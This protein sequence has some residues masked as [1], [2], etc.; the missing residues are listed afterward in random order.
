MQLHADPARRF[1]HRV[2]SFPSTSWH[3]MLS[4]SPWDQLLVRFIYPPWT[5]IFTKYCF[6]RRCI[7]RLLLSFIPDTLDTLPTSPFQLA[8]SSIL[9]SCIYCNRALD[10]QKPCY[11]FGP[12]PRV[13]LSVLLAAFSTNPVRVD[14]KLSRLGVSSCTRCSNCRVTQI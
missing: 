6:A 8:F 13:L 3:C 5:S 2:H 12:C 10:G 1:P 9:E 4:L 11:P 14:A 7:H